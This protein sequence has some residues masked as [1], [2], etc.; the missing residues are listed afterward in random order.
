METRHVWPRK[1][2]A[3]DPLHF[4]EAT[5]RRGG[6]VQRPESYL[7]IQDSSQWSILET[8]VH[9]GHRGQTAILFL[10]LS[11]V[12]CSLCLMRTR[13]TAKG[14]FKR[15]PWSTGQGLRASPH[16]C[17]V[18]PKLSTNCCLSNSD[19]PLLSVLTPIGTRSLSLLWEV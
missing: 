8:S 19:P 12:S 16:L 17:L 18:A 4:N 6:E 3:L 15:Q 11:E 14:S 2:G 7:M 5:R 9:G 1:I 10:S 13:K